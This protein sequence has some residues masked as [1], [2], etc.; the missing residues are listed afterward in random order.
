MDK[1]DGEGGCYQFGIAFAKMCPINRLFLLFSI[2]YIL[3]PNHTDMRKTL[4]TLTAVLILSS[5]KSLQPFQLNF[6]SQ[7]GFTNVVTTYT[8]QE[9]GKL[10]KTSSSFLGKKDLAT[11]NKKDLKEIE[12]LITK[13]NFAGASVNQPG[14]MSSFLTLTRDGKAYTN[15]WASGSSSGNT[16][17]DE[18]LAKL[19]S[20]VPKQQ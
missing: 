20:L 3:C 8:L 17:L 5:C 1:A 15:T 4:I 16:A 18:L 12:A 7:G 10:Y 6:G 14:N 19:N 13:A 2:N 11:V 9:D